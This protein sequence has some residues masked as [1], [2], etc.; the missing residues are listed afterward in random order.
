[1]ETLKRHV[2]QIIAAVLVMVMMVSL[3]TGYQQ[4]KTVK[5]AGSFPASGVHT[6]TLSHGSYH[7]LSGLYSSTNAK[8]C[9]AD[10]MSSEG[11]SRASFCMSPGVSE[12]TKAGAYKSSTY[13]SGYG[14]KYYKALISFYYDTKGDYKTDAVRYAT[15]FFVWRTVVLERNH[16][17]N[18]AASA[19]DGS[20][21]KSGFI[22]SMKSLMGYSD[23]TATNLYNKAY[24]YI[25]NGADGAYNNKVALLKWVASYSQTMLTGKVYSNKEVKVKINKDLDQSGSGISLAGTKYEIHEGSKNGTKVGT[26]TLDKNG[27]DTVLLKKDGIYDKTVSYYI[28]ETKNVAGTTSNKNKKAMTFDI[29]WGKIKD[30][31]TGATLSLTKSGVSGNKPSYLETAG[32]LASLCKTQLTDIIPGITVSVHK[33]DKATKKD[34]QNAQFTI[35]AYNQKTGKYNTKVTKANNLNNDITNPIVTNKNGNAKSAKLY[36][37]SKNLGKFKIVE[38]KA[39]DGYINSK[40]SKVFS[41]KSGNGTTNE[42]QSV[43]FEIPNTKTTSTN[44][45]VKLVKIDPDTQTPIFDAEFSISVYK[46]KKD[47]KYYKYGTVDNGTPKYDMYWAETQ[48]IAQD[49]D[50]SGNVQNTYTTKDLP[51]GRTY[52][53]EE[54]KRPSGHATNGGYW[55]FGHGVSG[56]LHTLADYDKN[57]MN[58]TIVFNLNSDGS[59]D[60]LNNQ[61]DVAHKQNYTEAIEVDNS[62]SSGEVTVIKQNDKTG[63]LLSGAAFEL[64]EVTKAEYDQEGYVPSAENNDT[65]AGAGE[66]GE[67]GKLTFG[68]LMRI[69]TSDGPQSWR[70]NGTVL[71]EHYYILVETK[72]PDGYRLPAK[73]TTKVYVPA[74]EAH[75]TMDSFSNAFEKEYV[76]N[77]QEARLDLN[78]HKVSVSRTGKE[79]IGLKGA[80]FAL[81]K[82]QKIVTDE[83]TGSDETVEDSNNNGIDDATENAIGE[84][85]E[86][87]DKSTAGATKEVSNKVD[88]SELTN[89]N[90]IDFDYSKLEPVYDDITTD[91]NGNAVVPE[92]LGAGGY[93]L[94]ETKAPKNYLTAE[95]QYIF[96][97]ENSLYNTASYEI[98]VQDKEFEAMVHAIKKD[99]TTG[100]VIKQAGVGFKVKNLDTGEYVKQT[101]DYYDEPEIEG[102]PH[103]L[104]RSEVTDTFYTDENGEVLLPNVL[105]IGHYQLE[106]IVAPKGYLINKT[107]IKF[108]I[109]DEADYYPDDPNK[110]FD[111]DE[112]TRDVVINLECKDTPTSTELSKKDI[113]NQDELVG[114]HLAVWYEV[115][116]KKVYVDKWTSTKD[117]HMIKALAVGQEYHM[118]EEIPADGYVTAKDIVFVVKDTEQVQKVEMIDDVTKTKISKTDITTGALIPGAELEITDLNGKV[119]AKWT[120]TNEP[121]YIEKLPIGDY[122]LKEKKAPTKDGYV[123][124]EDVKFTVKDT[125]EI[126]KVEMTD[127][128]TKV[129]ISKTDMVTG[130]LVPGAELEILDSTGK[131]VEKWT[132]TYH[133]HMI[134][135]LAVGDYTLRETKAPTEDGYVRAEDVKFTV[136]E[137]GEIQKVEMKDDYTRVE[138]SKLDTEGNNLPGAK[139]KVVNS[140]GKTVDSWT[141][142]GKPHKMIK[143]PT[144]EYTLIEVEPPAGYVTAKDVKFTITDTN[145]VQKVGMDDDTTKVKVLKVDKD[146]TKALGNAE[147][148]FKADG[149]KTVK[150][151]TNGQ[152]EAKIE[153]QLVAGKTYVVSETKAPDGYKKGADFKFTVKDT[154]KVQ[155]LKITNERSGEA[156]PNTPNWNDKGGNSPQTG[157]SGSIVMMIV[158]FLIAL[159]ATIGISIKM[160]KNYEKD[161][162][163]EK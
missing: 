14:I 79:S 7:R 13:Q 77:N 156:T 151:K 59:I 109:D 115:G 29:N 27:I 142:D 153:G 61:G 54:T 140:E 125:A 74:N 158:L 30:G 8:V 91:E 40:A 55:G 126:Q 138:V 53:I 84:D 108:T 143:L 95:P 123:K 130:K 24:G 120:S 52:R 101:V 119:Y 133:P 42:N 104:I 5:A 15:Q 85:T 118:T 92:A 6:G 88:Y 31:S 72:A 136:R 103:E 110:Q 94:V 98:E 64:W 160:R 147:F 35:Y 89:E 96:I 39:P 99:I 81:Y 36:Y 132:S 12:T 134:E 49:V 65:L 34:L 122:I 71:T 50:R 78:L 117:K 21:F 66:T 32:T 127:D 68:K 102:A 155:P 9:E 154:P 47:G 82:V 2:R 131:V 16:K 10:T 3:V 86:I 20:G 23:K 28:K 139:L 148:V 1:M 87:T 48:K 44:Y 57:N 37:T 11:D 76:I 163:R 159:G 18:F 70:E 63:E 58:M 137:T 38:T 149:S 51:A 111:Y 157:E 97:D 60:I 90:Y 114:A 141:S 19:Y 56:M 93:V 152:G 75:Y 107:P 46:N 113:T 83:E 150:V 67:D 161:N 145:S 124:A 22:A 4:E 162:D 146:T 45:P 100:E 17:G 80:K 121:Y 41:I 69:E 135:K 105:P 144:G 129:E 116:G 62:Q 106:E 25:K 112:N 26:F 33:Y 73:N 43:S 128:Y